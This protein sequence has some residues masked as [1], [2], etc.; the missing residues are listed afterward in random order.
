MAVYGDYLR[1]NTEGIL[2]IDG[3]G[4]DDLVER[5][6]SPLFVVS[7]S[8]I[9]QNVARMQRALQTG[10]E[11]SA[12]LFAT[13]ANNNLAVR[14]VFTLAG[15]GGDAFGPAELWI[16]LAAGTPS[17]LVVLNGFN[18]GDEEVEMAIDAGVAIHLDAPDE[19][20]QV[21]RIAREKGAIAK[22]GV[23]SRLLLHAFDEIL[24]DWPAAGVVDSDATIGRNMRERDK[25]GVSPADFIELCQA[26]L[27]E[28]S[29]ELVGL[30]HHMGR[31]RADAELFRT[32]VSEQLDLAA[33]IREATGWTP[34]YFDFGGGMAFGRPEG[35]GPMAKDRGE[36][37]YEDY[38]DAIT[39]AFREGLERHGLGEPLLMIEPGR[40]LASNIGILLTR[41]GM[42][43]PVPETGQVWLGV[44]A[45]Q[46]HLLNTLSGAFYY[47]PVR[48]TE[49]STR[50]SERVNI[51]DPQCWYGNLAMDVELP[52]TVAGDLIAF[53]DTG[54]YCESQSLNFNALPR[55][56]TVMVS[57]GRAEVVTRRETFNDVIGRVRVPARLMAASTSEGAPMASW[58][59]AS[60]AHSA[61]AGDRQ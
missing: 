9:R 20:A 30:H 44:D 11:K 10:Y 31:E 6:G 7:E 58:T 29:V 61:L 60:P 2:E 54:A 43:K 4:C 16:T 42:R 55:P 14:R 23:R 37:S 12:V 34:N 47:H 15:A 50:E 41:V 53:L 46:N 8:Q 45:C 22:V 24:S 35:H 19:L 40:A 56:A 38:A 26:A 49:D 57:D 52:R 3:V 32:T 39:G 5:F 27:D 48:V 13:K 28:P 1:H 18:K 21:A 59:P 33:E 25:F 36:Y 17:S 51:A